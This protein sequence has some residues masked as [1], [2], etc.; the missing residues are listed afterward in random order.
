[1]IPR[2]VVLPVRD[3]PDYTRSILRLLRDEEF[4][5]ALVLDNGSVSA[6]KAVLAA[7]AT[8]DNRLVVIDAAG[9]RI[10]AMWNLGAR[11]AWA[12]VG[13]P[14]LT[15]DVAFLNNDIRFGRGTLATL[16]HV[17]RQEELGVVCP[18]YQRA[19]DR[20]GIP[21]TERVS[22][23]YRHGGIAGWCFMVRGEVMAEFGGVDESFEWWAGDDDLIFSIEKA[24]WPVAIVRGLP[25]EHDGEATVRHHPTFHA[26]KKR[27][28]ERCLAKW[29]R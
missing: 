5:R 9:M 14:D 28:L 13:G 1:M 8:L 4:D 20:P 10:Y 26:A 17:L 19:L 2:F 18:D 27:D 23:T 25:L 12:F 6:T 21:S 22:G 3:E 15:H 24:G 29:G 7:A 16:S 11:L